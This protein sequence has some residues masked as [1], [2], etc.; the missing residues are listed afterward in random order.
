M[1]FIAGLFAGLAA[2]T[3]AQAEVISVWH[4]LGGKGGEAI[5]SLCERFN[6]TQTAH[7]VRCAYQGDYTRLMQKAVAAYRAGRQPTLVQFLDIAVRDLMQSRAVK[8][9]A[10]LDEAAGDAQWTHELL[11]AVRDWY[12]GDDGRL[13]GQPFNVSTVLLYANDTLLAA[14]GVAAA[15]STWDELRQAARQL[16]AQG[17]RCPFV[18]DL[19]AWTVLEQFAATEGIAIAEPRNGYD[20]IDARYAVAT[21][22]IRAHVQNLLDGYREGWLRLD[23]QTRAGDASSAFRSG[24]CAMLLASTGVWVS[25]RS[26]VGATRRVSAHPFPVRQAQVRHT[27]SLGGGALYLMRGATAG[28]EAAALAFLR[29]LRQ[30]VQQLELAGRTGFLPYTQAAIAAYRDT[31]TGK[32]VQG[33]AVLVGLDSLTL[34]GASGAPALRLGFYTQ[35]RAAWKEEMQSAF[36]GHQPVALACERTQQR[37]NTLLQRFALTYGHGAVR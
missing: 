11:P 3:S 17:Q 18:T 16:R 4:A 33:D 34:P 27:T 25:I 21:P 28:Q 13:L 6:A 10:D 5:R 31:V 19:E 23:S 1:W 15:P 14:A 8:P 24:E 30:P 35:F 29:F 9:I 32:P 12:T 20:T 37:G 7:Q 22:S 2:A 26:T 36:A